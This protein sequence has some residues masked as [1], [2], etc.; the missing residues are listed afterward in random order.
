MLEDNPSILLFLAPYLA[1]LVF[2]FLWLPRVLT[3]EEKN[4]EII[5]LLQTFWSF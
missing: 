1:N 3:L 5:A 2:E 4:R